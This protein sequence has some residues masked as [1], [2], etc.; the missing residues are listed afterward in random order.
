MDR[1]LQFYRINLKFIRKLLLIHRSGEKTWNV[2]GQ[3]SDFSWNVLPRTWWKSLS[4]NLVFF[5]HVL[6]ILWNYFM[7][8]GWW[9]AS[10]P[11]EGWKQPLGF[12]CG[13]CRPARKS[14]SEKNSP[15]LLLP[16][17]LTSKVLSESGYFHTHNILT[18]L[19][20]IITCF[21]NGYLLY[22]IDFIY[23]NSK[24]STFLL[25]VKEIWVWD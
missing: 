25:Y 9:H 10:L 3:K 18:G 17:L 21:G 1:I 2:K 12:V 24:A 6:T 13:V 16:V 7:S 23:W 14:N 19:P 22:T 20:G 5:Q 8:R 4:D 15:T 11:F